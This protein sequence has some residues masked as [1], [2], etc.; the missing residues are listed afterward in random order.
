MKKA[1]VLKV[2]TVNIKTKLA[3]YKTLKFLEARG[4]TLFT[5]AQTKISYLTNSLTYHHLTATWGLKTHPKVITKVD[6]HIAVFAY[7]L[8]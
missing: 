5:I 4:Q 8:K 7:I 1:L 2:L 6:S 3:N